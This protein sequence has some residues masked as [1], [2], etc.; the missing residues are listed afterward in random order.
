LG[1]SPQYSQ[2]NPFIIYNQLETIEKMK[3]KLS[4]PFNKKSLYEP[5]FSFHTFTVFPDDLNYAGSLFGG[6]LL[7]EM[8]IA[9]IKAV[10]RMLY[11]TKCDGAVTASVEKVDFKAAAKLGDIIELNAIINRLGTTSIDVLVSVKSENEQGEEKEICQA[12]FTFVSLRN[13][14][15]YSHRM[16]M[17]YFS[18]N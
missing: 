2:P 17:N 7:A 11:A 16:F 5:S 8:D 12:K 1:I 9:A 15:P 18:K 6:K 3:N 10:R 13:G 4:S 14:K